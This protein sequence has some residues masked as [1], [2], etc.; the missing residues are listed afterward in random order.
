[1]SSVP[2]LSR[3]LRKKPKSRNLARSGKEFRKHN[4]FKELYPPYYAET[5]LLSEDGHSIFS[6]IKWHYLLSNDKSSPDACPELGENYSP[7]KIP[8]AI[9]NPAQES[10]TVLIVSTTTHLKGP[11]FITQKIKVNKRLL[12]L[13]F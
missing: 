12:K 5:P 11:S 7:N 9:L 3:P 6:S 2:G 13:I 1:V 4:R 8:G 10:I